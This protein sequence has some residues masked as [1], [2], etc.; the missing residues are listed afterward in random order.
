MLL[1]VDEA[2]KRGDIVAARSASERARKWSYIGILCGI[3]DFVIMAA[4]WLII[5]YG[6]W[7]IQQ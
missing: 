1:Q 4:I 6:I 5:L 7:R 2:Y 3:M